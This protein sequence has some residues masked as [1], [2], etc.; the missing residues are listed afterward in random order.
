MDDELFLSIKQRYHIVGDCEKLRHAV[1]VA[2]QVAGTNLSVLIT[3]ESG[4]G[5]EILPKIIHD[6]SPRKH[7]KYIAVNCGAIPEGTLDSEL[8]GH[9]K[10]SFTGALNDR[11]GY[12]EEADGG[13]IFLDEVGELPLPTQARLL[14]VLESGEFIKVGSST[15]QKTDVRVVAA[16]NLDIQDAVKRGRF[17]EDLY[18]R[19]N[20]IPITLPALRERGDDIVLLFRYFANNCTDAYKMP[21]LSLSADGEELLKSY[22]WPGNVR[23][24]KNVTEQVALLESDRLID[25]LTLEKYLPR[26]SMVP[27]VTGHGD[28]S[29]EANFATE[30]EILYKILFDMRN[31]MN[32]LKRVVNDLL[33]SSGGELQKGPVQTILDSGYGEN[34]GGF[35]G[36]ASGAPVGSGGFAQPGG[37]FSQGGGYGATAS[38]GF[39]QGGGYAQPGGYAQAGGAAIYPEEVVVESFSLEEQEKETI[40]K[41]L[42]KNGGKRKP[43]ARDLGISERTLY[44][45]IKDY[46]ISQ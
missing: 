25:A 11:K 24:L 40:Q 27:I 5:K 2:I 18:Y 37:G 43:T 42:R 36:T 3:G 23:Q 13:T 34:G 30:R 6:N 12:F 7:A 8:F 31:D 32:E 17:R 39:A 4:V 21:R 35:S 15:V 26:D 20:T 45:K 22:S 41:A 46:H 1:D 29:G 19:L 44:R 10:G 9:I 28:G 38:G 14:R 16:T 33:Q